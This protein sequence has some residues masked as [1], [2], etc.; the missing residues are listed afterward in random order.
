MFI[1]RNTNTNVEIENE[2]NSNDNDTS[3]TKSLLN[4]I[5]DITSNL[6]KLELSSPTDSP[7]R[8]QT[9]EGECSIQLCLNQF[10]ALELM[11]GNNKVRCPACTERENKVLSAEF[12]LL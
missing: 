4:G 2:T 12:S 1:S 10:T 9:K 11:T 6:T 3:A 8:Y 7:T 5:G